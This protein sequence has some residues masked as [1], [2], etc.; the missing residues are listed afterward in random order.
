LFDDKLESFAVFEVFAQQGDFGCGDPFASVSFVFPTL[1]FV[2]GAFPEGA[3][4]LGI[5]HFAILLVERAA[6]D[7]FNGGELCEEVLALALVWG[8]MTHG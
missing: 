4:T 1:V 8:C 7:S 2:V 6:F 5:R 3:A